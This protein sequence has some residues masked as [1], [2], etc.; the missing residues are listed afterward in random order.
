MLNILLTVSRRNLHAL[1]S[2]QSMLKRHE[3]FVGL[4]LQYTISSP[5]KGHSSAFVQACLG[6]G[7]A[8]FSASSSAVRFLAPGVKTIMGSGVELVVGKVS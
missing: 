8:V 5:T 6:S 3:C 2:R 1:I 7:T 4:N